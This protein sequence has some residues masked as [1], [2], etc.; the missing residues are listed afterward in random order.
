V[1]VC[2]VSV[3][4]YVCVG[5]VCVCVWGVFFSGEKI[6]RCRKQPSCKEDHFVLF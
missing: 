6:A 1:C 3:C 5:G 4:V 2:V